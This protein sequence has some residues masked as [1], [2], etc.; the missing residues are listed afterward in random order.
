MKDKVGQMPRNICVSTDAAT[1]AGPISVGR[2]V[3]ARTALEDDGIEDEIEEMLARNHIK[4]QAQRTTLHLQKGP[5]QGPSE[6]G[7]PL[8]QHPDNASAEAADAFAR[9]KWRDVPV[10]RRSPTEKA[11]DN[12]SHSSTCPL[13]SRKTLLVASPPQL[14]EGHQ[15]GK[16]DLSTRSV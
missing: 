13:I 2:S 16:H 7:G 14:K 3:L 12:P 6:Q 5:K 11:T 10:V 1:S 8:E 4:R 15:D 9:I